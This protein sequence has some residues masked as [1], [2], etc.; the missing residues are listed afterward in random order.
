MIAI[1][2]RHLLLLVGITLIWG[3]NLVVA[4]VGV[5]DMPPV[6]F[7]ALRFGLLAL[8]TTP[9][10]R[11]H[12]EATGAIVVTA[13]LVGGLSFTLLF[14]GIA[15]ADNISSVAIVSQLGVPFATLLSIALL[16]EQVRWRRW[17]GIGLAFLGVLLMGFDPAV[18]AQRASLAYVTASA[19]VGSLGL[20][21]IKRLPRLPPLELQAWIAWIS[22]PM[23]AVLSFLVERDHL[24]A[25]VTAGWVGWGA[26]LY[27]TVLSSLLAHTAY[28]FLVQ[29]YPVTSIAPLT[30][31]SPV[32][33]VVFG[34][35]L[36]GDQLTPRIVLGGVCT[37][38]G[39]L[40]ITLREKQFVD[41]GS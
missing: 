5:G 22:W 25:L 14:V 16:G 31:L 3:L 40:V 33:S 27:T 28:F 19:F 13:L 20:I 12:G 8:M 24:H 41:T 29:R 32:F 38:A 18:F 17:T 39:V 26:L 15:R 10:L 37:L 4:K 21:G 34:V 35:L 36:L 9:F 1:A 23:L 2:P 7:T 6:L 11:W 30:V